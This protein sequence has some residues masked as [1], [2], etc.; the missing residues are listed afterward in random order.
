MPLCNKCRSTAIVDGEQVGDPYQH[1]PGD[2]LAEDQLCDG[3]Q[4]DD[5]DR[6]EDGVEVDDLDVEWR[7]YNFR[8]TKKESIPYE[9]CPHCGRYRFRWVR[10]SGVLFKS[11]KECKNRLNP[12]DH[13]LV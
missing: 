1:D 13:N 6:F 3:C 7:T 8:P 5:G 4:Y 9:E 12:N 2:G 11:C 10:G